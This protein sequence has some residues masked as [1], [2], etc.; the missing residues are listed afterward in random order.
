M[1]I[2]YKKIKIKKP[3]QILN[4]LN[5]E[6]KKILEEGFKKAGIKDYKLETN[7]NEI[8]NM[9]CELFL[10][11]KKI[12]F[13]LKYIFKKEGKYKLKLIFKKLLKNTSLMFSE[14]SSLTSLNLF[15]FNTNN[16]TNMDSM[17]NICSSLTSLNLSNFNTNN[18]TKMEYMFNGCSSLSCEKL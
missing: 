1:W 17:F 5:E 9:N 6:G 16:V 10:K 12:D 13:C 14:C 7:D 2:W 18:V 15:N 3:I 8:N 4:C 11:D